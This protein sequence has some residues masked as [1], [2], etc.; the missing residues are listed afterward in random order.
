MLAASALQLIGFALGA[1]LH[2]F[3]LG[4]LAR[5]LKA[6]LGKWLLVALAAAGSVWYSAN[7][8]AAFHEAIIGDENRLLLGRLRGVA[9]L[10]A[11]LVPVLFLAFAA[12]TA[13]RGPEPLSRKFSVFMGGAFG[14]LGIVWLAQADPAVAA[15]A[16]MAPALCL[17][18]FVYR[19]NLCGLLIS[20]RV[21]VVFRL[22]A[23]SAL[24]LYLVRLISSFAELEFRAFGPLLEILLILAAAVLWIP[25]Y[26]WLTRS[27]SR[28][29]EVFAEFSRRLVQ[30]AAGILDL[31]E[32]LEYMADQVGR[33]FSLKRVVLVT[34]GE[35]RLRR[36]FGAGER[37]E[38][39]E[40]LDHLEAAVRGAKSDMLCAQRLDD[41]ALKSLLA[42]LGFSYLFPLWYEDRLKG[43]LLVDTS[44]H[45]YLD[46]DETLFLG[47]S[48]Q[49][50]H[51]I[52]T[53]RLVDE[54]IALEKA[55]LRQAHLATLGKVA[56]TI[57]HEV[58]NPLS[59]IK[60]LAQLMREDP[61]L[62]PR[63]SRD[64]SFIV[65]ETD[66]LTNCVQQLLTFS[67]PAPP[68]SADVPL[69]SLLDNIAHALARDCDSQGI[70]IEYSIEPDLI[71][72][73]ADPQIVQQTVLN[74]MLNAVQACG[75]GAAVRLEASRRPDGAIVIVVS[76]QG[77]GIP[78]EIRERVFDAF[79][80]TKQKGTGLGLAIVRKNV[81]HMGGEITLESP[82]ADGRGTRVTLVLP[83]ASHSPA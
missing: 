53:Q 40:A 27:L 64:V 76:D 46:Q 34:S 62:D 78:P 41:P 37:I 9:T 71:V 77:A 72:A 68:A 42:G 60:T 73:G 20:R 58:K 69:S 54:K 52:E 29:T 80:T 61:N 4:L 17:V 28:R 83:Q 14:L 50:S 74:L 35:P 12:Y 7:A 3:V 11:A 5:G 70:R 44:P 32:R 38:P 2:L 10:A 39:A 24:Y 23:M 22:A 66:R 19:Y 81:S 21:G 75:R 18:Y 45:L 36:A 26:A 31:G 55:L 15:F 65:A 57:A 30:E 63:F 43:M 47:L 67:R 56:A 1:A 51:S 8:Y 13:R 16:A 79:F 82:I 48:R 6:G 33:A 49:I 59:S 25:L